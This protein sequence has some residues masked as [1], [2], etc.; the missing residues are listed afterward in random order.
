[1]KHFLLLIA[2]VPM[3]GFG[4][5]TGLYGK[6]TT[7][8][9]QGHGSIPIVTSWFKS[10]SFYKARNG[11][12]TIGRNLFDGGVRF[13]VSRAISN[14]FGFGVEYGLEYQNL[15]ANNSILL[16]YTGGGFNY[17]LTDEIRH[18][19]INI[20]TFSIMPKFEFSTRTNLLPIGLSHQ[21]GI[22]YT[23]TR[24]LED[25][26]IYYIGTQTNDTI[27]TNLDNGLLD[28]SD[29]WTGFTVM[30]QINMR[31]PVSDFLMITCGLRYTAN[32]VRNT[33]GTSDLPGELDMSRL[34]KQKRNET[35]LQLHIGAA[36]AF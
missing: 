30:Y 27:T 4:Q 19:A 29:R 35:F 34:V 36:I 32:F 18:Q 17:S 11:N 1:M 31:T 10:R 8:E 20:S 15:I 13:G 16:E 25:D 24:M 5:N 2:F 33:P 9:V 21:V 6:K 26:Y 7:F 23:S 28:Y 22:G 3:I 14:Q 12:L